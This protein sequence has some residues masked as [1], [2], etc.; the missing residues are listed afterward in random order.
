MWVESFLWFAIDTFWGVNRHCRILQ[1]RPWIFSSRLVPNSLSKV[2]LRVY[3]LE[4]EILA[5]C[6]RCQTTLKPLTIQY[7][8]QKGFLITSAPHQDYLLT[9]L[10]TPSHIHIGKQSYQEGSLTGLDQMI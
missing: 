7:E 6:I 2:K 9:Q 1:K 4:T 3:F 5:F 10:L 8:P